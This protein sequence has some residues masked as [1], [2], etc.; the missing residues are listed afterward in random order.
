MYRSKQFLKCRTYTPVELLRKKLSYRI[1]VEG[2]GL[3][4]PSDWDRVWVD[5]TDFSNVMNRHQRSMHRESRV[6]SSL[7]CPLRLVRLVGVLPMHVTALTRRYACRA[8]DW[9]TF[10]CKF[11]VY[12][13]ST[14]FNLSYT[15][16]VSTLLS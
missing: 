2:W 7:S 15:L 10:L 16:E 3:V 6:T 11:L 13:F 8:P 12:S 5:Q 14:L 9:C 4:E 1:V